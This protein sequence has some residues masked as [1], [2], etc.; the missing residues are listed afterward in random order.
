MSLIDGWVISLK[1]IKLI[2]EVDDSYLD[3][4]VNTFNNLYE[5]NI[6][7]SWSFIVSNVKEEKDE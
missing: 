6:I 4:I 1:E 3:V 5:N 2:L 7:R